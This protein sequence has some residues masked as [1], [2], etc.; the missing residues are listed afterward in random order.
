VAF[1]SPTLKARFTGDRRRTTIY[2][3]LVPTRT[4]AASKIE[5][6]RAHNL[7]QIPWLVHGFST[8]IGGFSQ[9]YGGR[10]LNLGYTHDDSREAVERN[11]AAFLAAIG[12]AD[13]PLLG[14]RQ[15]HSDLIWPGEDHHPPAG[16]GL[17][18]GTAGILLTVRTADCHPI[19]LVD[20]RKRAVV[21]LHAGWRGTL[22]RIAEKGVGEMRRWFNSRP[23]DLR[24]AIGPGIHVCCYEVGEDVRE[25]FQSQFTYSN[26]LFTET[27]ETD[28]I[29]ER[30]PLLF[31]TA[32]A[33]GHIEPMLPVKI[34]LDLVEAN[35]RQLLAAGLRAR[36]ISASTLCTACRTD[37][38]FSHRAERGKTGRMMAAIGILEPGR[39]AIATE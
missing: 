2:N 14:V 11:R 39:G 24:A 37:L 5:I 26:A 8:R 23:E 12:T 15:I 22:R 32:R 28:A 29:R 3:A 38:L 27:K 20:V 33:P 30:Y 35:R 21:T 17:V 16:D 6:I 31:L 36:H 4:A 34:R 19:L 1:A 9:V 7:A 13:W 10:S 18:T 25:Q